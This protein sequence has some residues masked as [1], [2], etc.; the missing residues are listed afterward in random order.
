MSMM[1]DLQ[2]ALSDE[3]GVP[4]QAQFQT[5]FE[6]SVQ[7]FQ[8]A[9]EIT[10][11]LVDADESQFLNMTYRQ[12]DKPTNVLSFPFEQPLGRDGEPLAADLLGDIVICKQVVEQEAREQN[13]SLESHWAHMVIHGC[14][15]LLGYDHIID[16]EAE[17]MEQIETEIMI[18]LGY[19]APYLVN[20]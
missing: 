11:R 5:W 15:H 14:L 3:S 1:L 6:Q 13:K 2:I 12:K 9:A 7:L 10:I 8:S 16:D 17:E 18:K 20:Q 19:D 4:T